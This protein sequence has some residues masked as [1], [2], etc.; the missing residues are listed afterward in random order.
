[1]TTRIGRL[2]SGIAGQHTTGDLLAIR[3][4]LALLFALPLLAPQLL[5]TSRL[6]SLAVTAA[7]YVIA[8]NGLHIVFS[9]T[10][11]LS[12]AHTTLWGLGA[13]TTA[14][15]IQ[16]Y[17]WATPLLFPFAAFA[18]ALGAVVIGIPAFR[19]GGFSFAIITFAFA[20]LMR[21]VANNWRSLT[22]G[23]DGITVIA[24]PTSLGP[25]SFDTFDHLDNFYYLALGVAYLSVVCVLL[26]R[27]S[28]LG[29]TF[30][31]IR[32]NEQLAQSV[33]INIYL[34][35]LI[36]FAISGAFAGVAGVLFVYHQSHVEPGPLSPFVAF[37]TIQ[38]LLMILIG[39]RSSVVGPTLGA[40]VVVFGPE[41][42]NTILGDVLTPARSQIIFGAAL[43]MSVLTAPNGIAGQ[44][45]EGFR[46]VVATWRK[47]RARG[48]GILVS[49]IIAVGS[50]FVPR[51][52]PD[53]NI[54]PAKDGE[55]A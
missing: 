31:A 46:A 18:G 40:I 20:E 2:T 15:L 45:R 26:I 10:G 4:P 32:E 35:K 22:N 5:P 7:I 23:S 13:Y 1:M 53:R 14:L 6:L 50:G 36:A 52:V 19:T 3:L 27:Q 21:L 9:Y 24:S 30:I 38:F 44:T 28:H 29:R 43:A 25:I 12:L 37:F 49:F 33:G 48:R 47:S 17:G 42:V 11:Q 54:D 34:H 55:A 51:L 39:G 16:H 8:V 41:L